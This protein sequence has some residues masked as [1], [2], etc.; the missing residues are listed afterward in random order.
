MPCLVCF[1]KQH[2]LRRLFLDGHF[3]LLSFLRASHS[4]PLLH[5]LLLSPWHAH[6]Y[7]PPSPNRFPPLARHLQVVL[8]R[9]CLFCARWKVVAPC[10]LLRLHF[11][12]KVGRCYRRMMVLFE[13]HFCRQLQTAQLLHSL[14][15][16]CW[17]VSRAR[18]S[19]SFSYL[20]PFPSFLL[21][22][23]S[24]FIPSLSL[25]TSKR[26]FATWY[27]LRRSASHRSPVA[28]RALSR[29]HDITTSRK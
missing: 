12:S 1:A 29:H 22:S 20:S 17:P 19:E 8:F 14:H 26:R 15:F 13:V 5:R 3:C 2:L 18:R 24:S 4:Y 21:P 23:S 10:S 7:L 16:R 25:T 11:R 28:K 9:S 27:E 6:P